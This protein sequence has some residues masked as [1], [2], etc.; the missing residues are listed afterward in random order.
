MHADLEKVWN[1]W[2]KEQL[3]DALLTEW[4]GLHD[5][6]K[7]LEVEL[8]SSGERADAA[9]AHRDEL[10][11]EERRLNLKLDSYQKRVARAK[12]SIETGT[13]S[14]YRAAQMQADQCAV[15]IDEVE[16]ELLELMER[17]EDANAKADAA[18]SGKAHLAHRL[19]AAKKKHD[20]RLPLLKPEF[21]DATAVRDAA[22]EGI[23]RDQLSRYD[24]LR[25]KKFSAFAS[26]KDQTCHGCHSGMDG[27]KYSTLQRDVEVVVCRHCGR[28]LYIPEP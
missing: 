9:V 22:R 21:E 18:L 26:G 27:T 14:D 16:T 8:T 2:L 15:I 10:A 13:A 4:R 7:K 17:L 19:E 11:A 1:L 5:A 25:K 6:V 20:E 3:R 12:K 24:M 28:F 23:W